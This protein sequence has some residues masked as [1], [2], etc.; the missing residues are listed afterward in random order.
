[1]IDPFSEERY[2][3]AK[4]AEDKFCEMLNSWGYFAIPIHS[5]FGDRWTPLL[6]AQY[7]DIEVFD[8]DNNKQYF[9]D[10]KR[11]LDATVPSDWF[12]TITRTKQSEA[13]REKDN[14]WYALT[15]FLMT[16]WRFVKASDL[17]TDPLPV[18]KFWRTFDLEK[19]WR[20]QVFK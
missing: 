3:E 8:V 1:M 19:Y 20:Q 18:G 11:T 9:V 14:A 12:G 7:G 2:A 16:D 10:V 13:F 15:N 17:K 4:K 6:D 5:F